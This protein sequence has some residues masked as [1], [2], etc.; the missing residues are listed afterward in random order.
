M[1]A[2]ETL[3]IAHPDLDTEANAAV[4][5]RVKEVISS[6]GGELGEVEEWGK[7][8]LAYEINK[9]RDGYFTLI[10]FNGNNDVLDELNHIFRITESI[11]RGIVVK[12]EK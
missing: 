11:L 6:K 7:R 1:K 2:Y 8:K 12:L 9:V 4:I 5:E 10:K 3:F